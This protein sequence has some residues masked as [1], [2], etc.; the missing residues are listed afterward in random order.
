MSDLL[1]CAGNGPF[2]RPLAKR[3]A[4]ELRV[5]WTTVYRWHRR[6]REARTASSLAPRGVGFP[7]GSQLSPDQKRVIDKVLAAM[8]RRPT[9]LRVV[10]VHAEV[11]RVCRSEKVPAPP[12]RSVDRRLRRLPQLRVRRRTLSPQPRPPVARGAFHLSRPR[13]EAQ[14]D[15][16][17]SAFPHFSVK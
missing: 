1:R 7:K 15:L 4:A 11:V 9:L 10:D 16:G 17:R 6:F 12:R 5:H 13:G 3:L 2:S 14:Q 8:G